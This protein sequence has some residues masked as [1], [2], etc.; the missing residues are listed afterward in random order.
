MDRNDKENGLKIDIAVLKDIEPLKADKVTLSKL[1]NNGVAKLTYPIALDL[2]A[3]QQSL[4]N[5]VLGIDSIHNSLS[6]TALASSIVPESYNTPTI[7][8]TVLKDF[9]KLS[10]LY[11]SSNSIAEHAKRIYDNAIGRFAND[12]I[13]QVNKQLSDTYLGS[14]IAAEAFSKHHSIRMILD[15]EAFSLAKQMQRQ[16][17]TM[18]GSTALKDIEKQ[19]SFGKIFNSTALDMAKKESDKLQ[20]IFRSQF[21]DIEELKSQVLGHSAASSMLE[22][23]ILQNKAIS[24]AFG[25][26]ALAKLHGI[27]GSLKATTLAALDITSNLYSEFGEVVEETELKYLRESIEQ[28]KSGQSESSLLST[29]D[30]IAILLAIIFHLQSLYL[31][32]QSSEDVKEIKQ[33]ID[34]VETN[35]VSQLFTIN[36]QIEELG[37]AFN[38]SDGNKTEYIV[39]R[40]VNLRTQSNTSK[41]SHVIAV[42]SPNQKVELLKRNKKWIYVGYFDYVEEVPKTGW[43]AKKYLKMVK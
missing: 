34:V 28:S 35:L 4:V 22:T 19:A 17:D 43:V 38:D 24:D 39:L 11:G 25:S 23:A 10:A 32:N 30:Y 26:T 13:Y 20:S 5:K 21:S 42:L 15:T 9:E 7:A 14:T 12:E 27:N 18:I 37:E 40:F 3:N 41:N 36:K 2:I 31:S 6:M 8:N 16:V 29:G 33:Q 1:F